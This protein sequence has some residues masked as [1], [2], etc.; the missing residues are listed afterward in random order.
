M[1]LIA[2]P[3][4]MPDISGQTTALHPTGL[5]GRSRRKDIDSRIFG[6]ISGVTTSIFR[7]VTIGLFSIFLINCLMEVLV[8]LSKYPYDDDYYY[9]YYYHHYYHHYHNYHRY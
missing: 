7:E 4:V 9:Y 6:G 3:Q 1:T 2:A 5:L 8:Q